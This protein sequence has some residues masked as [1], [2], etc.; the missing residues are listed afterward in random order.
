MT[1]RVSVVIPVY[2]EGE[3]VIPVLRRIHESIILS[4]EIIVVYDHQDDSTIPFLEALREEI[5]Q[6]R[7]TLNT[8]GRGPSFAIRFG[9]DQAQS[10]VTVV[11]MSDGCVDPQQIDALARLVE[12]I[13]RAHV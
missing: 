7:P 10:D 1:P 6:I 13:G 2:N 4:N 3:N 5:P 11:T 8:Y 12:Q 9:I